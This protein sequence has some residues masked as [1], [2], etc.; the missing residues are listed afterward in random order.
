MVTDLKVSFLWHTGQCMT[1]LVEAWNLPEIG[2]LR[3]ARVLECVAD[4]L[5]I[6]ITDA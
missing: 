2:N 3:D 4:I 5:C 6:R 1:H